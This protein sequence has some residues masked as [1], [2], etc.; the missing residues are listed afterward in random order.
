MNAEDLDNIINMAI[1]ASDPLVDDTSYTEKETKMVEK[2][3]RPITGVEFIDILRYGNFERASLV[4]LWVQRIPSAEGETPPLR[5]AFI[6]GDHG[7]IIREYY[8]D[9]CTGSM[10]AGFSNIEI[11]LVEYLKNQ[12]LINRFYELASSAVVRRSSV[13]QTYISQADSRN[14]S[15]I[16]DPIAHG[17][18]S[19]PVSR[20]CSEDHNV[21]NKRKASNQQQ[22][23]GILFTAHS[24]EN[25]TNRRRSAEVDGAITSHSKVQSPSASQ[26]ILLF[27]ANND[28][29]H[30]TRK[31]SQAAAGGGG[32]H[33]HG[34]SVNTSPSSSANNSRRSTVNSILMRGHPTDKPLLLESHSQ[35]AGVT[36][37]S[38]HAGGTHAQQSHHHPAAVH[39]QSHSQASS[40]RSTVHEVLRETQ[41]ILKQN[42]L[43]TP[44]ACHAAPSHEQAKMA[45]PMEALQSPSSNKEVQSALFS[46]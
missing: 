9:T 43:D 8:I 11:A 19:V 24:P 21:T 2:G 17:I 16:D 18:V 44:R 34:Y 25:T 36:I 1:T 27:A 26:S 29:D 6:L 5:R 42:D 41:D 30:Q 20:R 28:E 4:P 14:A 15:L 35:P 45:K 38:I 3:Y 33:G 7:E 12:T 40:R 10:V 37:G 46:V 13:G 32:G 22:Q 23:S 39:V 31:R